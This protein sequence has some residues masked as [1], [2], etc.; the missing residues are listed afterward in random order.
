MPAPRR[1]PPV[2]PSPGGGEEP[3][4]AHNKR[5]SDPLGKI[6]LANGAITREKLDQALASQRKSFKPLGLILREEF[7]LTQDALATAL[8][9]QAHTPRVY[10]R[11]FPVQKDAIALLEPDFCRQHEVIVFE[12]LGKL[13]CAALSNPSQR[14]VIKHIETHT[15]MEVKVFQAPFEDIQKKLG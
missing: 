11:F 12:K 4:S 15:G 7:G 10:L 13:L 2:R 14:N 3:G 5:E 9:K 6:L 1:L 8:K